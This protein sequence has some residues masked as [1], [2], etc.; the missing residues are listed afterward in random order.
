MADTEN[1]SPAFS[2]NLTD[3]AV[4]SKNALLVAV[5]AGLTYVVE[6]IGSLDLGATGVMLVPVVTVVINTL[7][8]WAKNNVP[9]E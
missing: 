5:A 9:A 4:I 8:K 1:K 3:V 7:V 2:L 6:N